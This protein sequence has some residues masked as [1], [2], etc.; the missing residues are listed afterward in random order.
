MVHAKGSGNAFFGRTLDLS[1]VEAKL[2]LGARLVTITG[3]AGIGKTRF[4]RELASSVARGAFASR[5]VV[6]VELA[7][8]RTATDVALAVADALRA[9]VP[10][11]GDPVV[12]VGRVLAGRPSQVLFL[13]EL[14]HL[15]ALVPDTV[16]VWLDA[17]PVVFVVTSRIRLGLGAEVIHD[18]PPLGLPER[19]K[20]PRGLDVPVAADAGAARDLFVNRAH[21]AGA[22]DAVERAPPELVSD[23]VRR[24]EGVPL[25]IELAAGRLRVLSLEELG[26]RLGRSLAVLGGGAGR[27]A[28]L[29]DALEASWALLTEPERAA[30]AQASVFQGSF[31]VVAAEAVLDLGP[32][33]GEVLDAIEGLVDKSM[34]QRRVDEDGN[35]RLALL[36]S[37]RAFVAERLE[38]YG[39]GR[40]ARRRHAEHHADRGAAIVDALIGA[41]SPAVAS[42]LRRRLIGDWPNLVA[43]VREAL[44]ATDVD[45]RAAGVALG[46]ALALHEVSRAL[47]S[48][49]ADAEALLDAVAFARRA[50]AL[51][52][53]HTRGMAVALVRAAD[54]LRPRA[55]T[56]AA[57]GACDEAIAIAERLDDP[58]LGAAALAARGDARGDAS[59]VDD[60]RAGQADLERA[61]ATLEELE[62]GPLRPTR[63][64]VLGRTHLRLARYHHRIGEPEVALEHARAAAAAAES[65]KDA[66]EE[67]EAQIFIA[68]ACCEMGDAARVRAA[69]SRARALSEGTA[70]GSVPAF[71]DYVLGVIKQ[72]EGDLEEAADLYVHAADRDRQL[73]NVLQEAASRLHLA[74]LELERGRADEA[75]RILPSVIA[76]LEQVGYGFARALAFAAL[77]VARAALGDADGARQALASAG[78]YSHPTIDACVRI[79]RRDRRS[80]GTGCSGAPGARADGDRGEE[81]RHPDDAPARARGLERR[82]NRPG[83]RA[84][85]F[86]VRR[87][88]RAPRRSLEATERRRAPRRARGSPPRRAG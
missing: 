88:R 13:D 33:G 26:A 72:E 65:I 25:A 16:G 51:P 84:R 48:R 31:D 74:R 21:A 34:L 22:G 20:R 78:A 61:I 30:L 58:E 85:G 68:A 15:A 23:I 76:A 66:R 2:A 69:C 73:G 24:L 63:R 80:R 1:S 27:H 43:A 11:G 17:S 19:R 83:R 7:L 57:I 86:L 75:A 50:P 6:I 14:E 46:A 47:G 38:Q 39:G 82:A 70:E 62:R 44:A 60:P 71:V 67:A 42:T 28:T 12:H 59:A 77:A 29:A 41:H 87:R 40:A 55:E 52:D 9:P 45:A 35:V 4:A 81:R 37:V 10:A 8:A 3:P 53:T 56:E 32:D 64:R 79:D 36:E 49:A 5:D 18:L 54:A